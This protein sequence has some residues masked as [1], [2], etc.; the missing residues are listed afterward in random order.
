MFWLKK[1]TGSDCSLLKIALRRL[2]STRRPT[3]AHR[4]HLHIARDAAEDVDDEQHARK[5]EHAVEILGLDVLVDRVR[6]NDRRD[7]RRRR[8]DEDRDRAR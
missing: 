8:G 2:K 6:D 4:A 7:E 5:D 3:A 1:A